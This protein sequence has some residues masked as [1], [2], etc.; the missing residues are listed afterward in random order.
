[1]VK[2]KGETQLGCQI[3]QSV[4]IKQKRGHSGWAWPAGKKPYKGVPSLSIFNW[5][6]NSILTEQWIYTLEIV[7]KVWITT[8][9]AIWKGEKTVKAERWAFSFSVHHC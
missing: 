6:L 5:K 4:S 2:V 1:M 7:P 9:A 8:K 3:N